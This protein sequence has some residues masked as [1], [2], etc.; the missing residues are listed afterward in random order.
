MSMHDQLLATYTDLM[1]SLEGLPQEIAAAQNDLSAVKRQMADSKTLLD[2]IEAQLSLSIEGKNAEERK[3]KLMQA[4]AA[5]Q[6]YQRLRQ[7][8][9]KESEEADTLTNDVDALT[10]QY[11]AVCYQ[12][13]LHSALL[14]YL[15]SA[16]APVP[17]NELG[18]VV[19]AHAGATHN[20]NGFNSSI[21]A[22]DAETLGL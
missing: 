11:G 17:L 15:G 7:T 13:R 16:G 12:T 6:N 3:A 14:T 1:T 8:M 2:T 22:I 10:R 19:F 5:H 20:T 21:T 4:L 18:D 9:R